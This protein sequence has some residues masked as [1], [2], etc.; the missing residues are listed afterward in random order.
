MGL[1]GLVGDKPSGAEQP[2]PLSE[3]QLD[4]DP[5]LLE[6]SPTLRRW[7]EQTPDLFE[8]NQHDPAFLPTVRLGYSY[9]S[10]P[11]QRSGVGIGVEDWLIGSLPLSISADYQTD[12]QGQ[13]SGGGNLQYYLLP[14]GWYGNVTPLVGY[15]W[16][17]QGNYHSD[18]INVGGK[19]VLTLSRTGA[20]D[21]RLSQMF[22]APG[23]RQEVGTS[24]LSVGYALSPHWRLATDLQ[25]QNSPGG[26]DSRVGLYLEWQP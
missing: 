16:V 21:I 1:I 17:Q 22:T 8:D 4:L 6:T 2:Q 26:K 19:I 5:A 20:A 23:S 12:F 9:F 10:D 3:N 25:Q 13:Q 11:D 7:L 14:L 18:G 24:T 15:R